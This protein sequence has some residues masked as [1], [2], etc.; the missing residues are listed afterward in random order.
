MVLNTES[1]GSLNRKELMTFKYQ[2]FNSIRICFKS[3]V[4]KLSTCTVE[5]SYQLAIR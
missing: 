4:R 5:D 2:Y 3:A 1:E